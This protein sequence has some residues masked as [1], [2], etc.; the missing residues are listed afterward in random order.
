[1][2]RFNEKQLGHKSRI[3]SLL[4]KFFPQMPDNEKKL[5]LS[6]ILDKD[7]GTEAPYEDIVRE[8]LHKLDPSDKVPFAGLADKLES[9]HRSALIMK[10]LNAD[11]RKE[12]EEATPQMVKD[13]RPPE[14]PEYAYLYFQ[15]QNNGFLA[16]WPDDDPNKK[17]LRTFKAITD[18][19]TPKQAL[20]HC[21]NFLYKHY[22]KGG[23]VLRLKD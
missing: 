21:V 15:P 23:G 9:Q 2:V 20:Q 14:C 6:C 22:R 17:P 3:M 7:V 13:L 8:A 16:S 19:V 1:M 5:R 11:D 18:K 12:M 4:G 10:R